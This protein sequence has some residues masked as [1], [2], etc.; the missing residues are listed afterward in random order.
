MKDKYSVQRIFFDLIRQK[1]PEYVSLVHELSEILDISYDSVYR[2]LRGEKSLS[3][4]E[5]KILCVKYKLSIDSI[6][7]HS[8]TDI[9]FQ[10]FVLGSNE[11][12]Y[13]EW[14]NI[15]Y[16]I[17]QSLKSA[18]AVEVIVIARD[19]PVYYLFDFPELI[20]F[21]MFFWKKMLTHQKE[22]HDTLLNINILPNDFIATGQRLL[23]AYNHISTVEI[24]NLETFTRIMQQIEFCRESKFLNKND[25]NILF[26][27]LEKMLHHIQMQ[28]EFG[29][30]YR[31]GETV[32]E[33][34]SENFKVYFN[35]I[36]VLDNTVYIEKDG[37]KSVYMTH[38]SLDILSTSNPTFCKQSENAI[39]G[40]MRSGNLISSTSELE[41]NRFFNAVH[42]RLEHYRREAVIER[43]VL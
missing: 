24:W 12:G 34:Y 39:K 19:L 40:I 31:Y 32:P 43:S 7:G 6:F 8:G 15:R 16:Q 13:S 26:K 10:P 9:L 14:L 28:T 17:L 1:I 20:A 4:E 27:V 38:N 35:E 30:K 42:T 36:M 37:L 23:Q 21:K 25:A 18:K 33:N 41:R 2:R 5:I 11:E 22:Y 29:Y 3:L